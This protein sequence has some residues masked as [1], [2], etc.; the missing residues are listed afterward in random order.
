LSPRNYAGC[1]APEELDAILTAVE[2]GDP[3]IHALLPDETDRDRR[4][5]IEA[6]LKGLRKNHEDPKGTP[7]SKEGTLHPLSGLIVGVKDLFHTRDFPTRAGSSLPADAFLEPGAPGVPTGTVASGVPPRGR[8][9]ASEGSRAGSPDGTGGRSDAEAVARLR[10]A[11]AIVL[12]KTVSTEF[13]YFA[14][15][16]TVNP[17]N[18]GHTPG[19]SSS[20]SAAAVAAGF[21]HA[22]L[23]TQTIGSISRPASF[24]GVV[25][26]KPS[27]GRISADGVVPFSP[28]AD[29]VGVIAADVATAGRVAAVLVDG[30]NATTAD[31]THA[32]DEIN[33]ARQAKSA[34]E[35][36]SA[37]SPGLREILH[38]S[39]STV[40]VPDDAYLAQADESA[41]RALEAAME[42]LTGLGITVLRVS[43]MDDIASINE[44]HRSMIAREFAEVHRF[45]LDRYGERY[46][47]RSV[48][49]IET[50]RGISE[51]THGNARRGQE[52][53]RKR[54][55][56]AIERHGA[57][58]W[59]APATPGE[60]PKGIDTTGDPVMNLPWTYAGVPTVSIPVD[61]LPHGTGPQG[62]PLGIQIA[63]PFGK[64]E[65]LIYLATLL[66]AVCS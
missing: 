60:A 58:V 31:T 36:I 6:A 43:I 49:L 8:G 10:S 33:A 59:I 19:G 38:E 57:T 14:P 9:A 37:V 45:W 65:E 34:S 25:G 22:A 20:G 17:R 47:P 66:E 56:A 21:C 1:P 32:K 4:R 42:R 27:F 50:G 12:G 18:T 55:D 62:L 24:C 48:A 53:L 46:H 3:R 40:L 2:T 30:W 41:Q 39:V 13:A 16:P 11:G 28:S 5:R 52:A 54:L 44:A 29:H 23:G 63:A 26:Y 15:G 51:E 64:D 7:T 35:G 61:R